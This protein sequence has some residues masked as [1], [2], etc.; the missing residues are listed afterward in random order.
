MRSKPLAEWAIARLQ[1]EAQ[2]NK[3]SMRRANPCQDATNE[4]TE[5][6]HPPAEPPVPTQT[7]TNPTDDDDPNELPADEKPIS[8][9][10]DDGDSLSQPN[11]LE[12]HTLGPEIGRYH[13][14]SQK[15]IGKLC[16]GSEGVRFLTSVRSKEKWRISFD[17]LKSIQKVSPLSQPSPLLTNN[18]RSS[19]SRFP[20]HEL[21]RRAQFRTHGRRRGVQGIGPEG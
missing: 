5:E 21:R 16:V 12:S 2:H 4:S 17:Q 20:P 7:T 14:T 18:Y 8:M 10:D 11:L 6:R 9:P 3:R 1:A 13:C 15:H 19:A